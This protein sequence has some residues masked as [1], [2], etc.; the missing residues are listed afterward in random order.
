MSSRKKFIVVTTINP[1][2]A[3]IAKFEQMDDWQVVIVGDRKSK[4][5]K[6]SENLT[7]LSVEN[8]KELGYQFAEICPYNHY[9]RKNIGYLYA[10]EHGAKIIYDT[11]D[12]NIPYSH[13]GA[14]AFKCDRKYATNRK[15]ANIYRYFTSEFIWPRGFPLDEI[16]QDLDCYE[17]KTNPI[18]IGVWQGLADKDPDVDAIFRLLYD[19]QTSFKD[20]P[21]VFL[22]KGTYC[23]FNSQNSTWQSQAFP[24]LYLPATTSFRFTD[25]LRGY[26]AQRLMWENDLRLGFTKATVYQE[27]NMHNLMQ[28]FAA[29]V[30]C[31]L[32][33]KETISTLDNLSL[34]RRPLVNLEIAYRELIGNSL[35]QS[36]ELKLCRTWIRDFNSLL[37]KSM[38]GS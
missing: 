7:F 9:A 26:I 3:G 28:D 34:A 13:W 2:S 14:P 22:G 16:N 31:Y 36:E 21:P 27:R 1:K 17:T 37:D 12:D 4:S 30:E 32:G 29:E 20:K 18:E 19:R 6:S 23:P 11:D 8:Q 24:Y 15:F 38:K 10:I 33:T 5:I 25:I 35:V